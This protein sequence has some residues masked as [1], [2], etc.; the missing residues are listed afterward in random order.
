MQNSRENIKININKTVKLKMALRSP[1]KIKSL[2]DRNIRD[3]RPSDT[4]PGLLNAEG[5]VT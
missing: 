1:R 4:K 5:Q 2:V 3:I